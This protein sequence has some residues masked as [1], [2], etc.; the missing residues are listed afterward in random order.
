MLIPCQI[1]S[2]S[3]EALRAHDLGNVP[4]TA[5]T[6]YLHFADLETL[7]LVDAT[8]GEALIHTGDRLVSI[9]NY[10]TEVIIQN[11]RT[12]PGLYV[13]R[14]DP[15]GWGINMANPTRNLLRVEWNERSAAV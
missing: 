8:T 15:S 7:G 13:V 14:A 1:G 9:R 10:Q 11:V 6:M 5:L 3:W 4:Q 12:P 2:R